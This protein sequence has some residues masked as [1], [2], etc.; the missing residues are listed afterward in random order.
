MSRLLIVLL[1]LVVTTG[2]ET[3]RKSAVKEDCEH[4][5]KSYN[6][7]IRWGDAEK[8]GMV[9]VAPDILPQYATAAEDLRRRKVQMADYRILA[10]E[11]SVENKKASAVVE[12]DYYALTNFKLKTLTYRQSWIYREEAPGVTPAWLMTTPL[13]DFR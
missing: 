4:S 10:Y 13:P 8:A 11:C 1:M 6:R 12:F 5:I 3:V 2:C 7:M 9:L